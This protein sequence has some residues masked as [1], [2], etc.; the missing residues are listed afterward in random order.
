MLIIPS[1]SSDVAAQRQVAQSILQAW[2]GLDVLFVNAGIAAL[3]P[4]EQWNEAAFD[5]SFAVNGKGPFSL[6]QS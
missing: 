1:D 4:V 6:I 5:H 2:G 3:K